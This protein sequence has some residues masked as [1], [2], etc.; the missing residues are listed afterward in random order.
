MES[1]PQRPIQLEFSDGV[2]YKVS[3]ETAKQFKSLQPIVR[4]ALQESRMPST[5]DDFTQALNETP[6]K[7]TIHFVDRPSEVMIAI[8]QYVQTQDVDYIYQASQRLPQVQ[9]ELAFQ[10]IQVKGLDEQQF[11]HSLIQ[12]ISTASDPWVSELVHSVTSIF[13]HPMNFALLNR[14]HLIPVLFGLQSNNTE[15]G[16]RLVQNGAIC[17]TVEWLSPMERFATLPPSKFESELKRLHSISDEHILAP[18]L[19]IPSHHSFAVSDSIS[20]SSDQSREHSR[21]G[22][23]RRTKATAKKKASAGVGVVAAVMRGLSLSSSSSSGDSDRTYSEVSRTLSSTTDKMRKIIADGD[24]EEDSFVDTATATTTVVAAATA[25][26]V[27]KPTSGHE[28]VVERK[29]EAWANEDH[30]MIQE[31]CSATVDKWRV[32]YPRF[33]EMMSQSP[34]R[35]NQL[36]HEFSKHRIDCKIITET[37]AC[38]EQQQR[39]R[40]RVEHNF[41]FRC[42]INCCNCTDALL[43]IPCNVL[44][45]TLTLRF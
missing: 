7:P 11:P 8:I 10:E 38:H 44:L 2:L 19:Q 1:P 4:K 21:N 9:K 37:H 30:R 5:T 27:T 39:T 18:Y 28:S 34:T 3:V 15:F 43:P 17:T 16:I 36:I 13:C 40:T 45:I 25:A 24:D 42:H 32:M 20:V 31:L 22:V 14:Y 26:S 23:S 12:A 29:R 35:R 6:L 41:P 33:Y